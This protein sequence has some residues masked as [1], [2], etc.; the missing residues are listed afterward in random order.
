MVLI[1]EFLFIYDKMFDS[2]LVV[3]LSVI[4]VLG[5]L[6]YKYKT[7]I[8][9][10]I[11]VAIAIV[12]SY[13]AFTVEA[14]NNFFDEDPLWLA[15]VIAVII[16]AIVAVYLNNTVIKPINDLVAG[17][18]QIATGDLTVNLDKWKNKSDE[19][20]EIYS[21]LDE[22]IGFLQ[23]AVA[24]MNYISK[25]SSS[26]EVNASSEEISSLTQEMS[27][28]AQ[29]QSIQI[30]ES[31]NSALTLRKNFDGKIDE[32]NSTAG[33]IEQI[34]SQVNMLA[35]NASIEAARAGEYGRGFAVVADN[36]RNLAN[37]SNISV[38][39]VQ[40]TVESLRFT[41]SQS[42]E[43]INSS[44]LRVAAVAEQTASGAEEASAATEEQAA[45]MEELTASAQ[46]FA[47]MAESLETII[48]KFIITKS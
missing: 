38:A 7:G 18:K 12:A 26:E 48:N 22:M 39:K 25:A 19:I 36:I 15:V 5:S 3:G 45:T 23:P 33:L 34:S 1:D 4:I 30:R 44:I 16:F 37:E 31:T 11:A 42:I 14:F 10:R 46:E 47:S 24:E 9:F 13:A 41:L 2:I 29:D 27:R 32:V 28:G 35:L 8:V 6:Y 40:E 20:G 17:S 21:A 43:D